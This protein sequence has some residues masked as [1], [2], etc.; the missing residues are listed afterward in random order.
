MSIR[1][2]IRGVVDD[3]VAAHQT[4]QVEGLAGGI[5]GDGAHFCILGDTLGGDVLITGQEDIR[6]DLVGNH[7]N[8]VLFV[9]LHGLLD[10]PFFPDPSR[11]VVGGAEDGGVDLVLAELGFHIGKVHSPHIIRIFYEPAVDNF[12]AVIFKGVGEADVGGAVDEH[13]VAPGAEGVQ[14]RDHAAQDAVFVADVLRLKPLNAV[15]GFVP[16]DDGVKIFRRGLEIAEGGVLGTLDHGLDNGGDN[17][18]IHVRHPHGDGLEAGQGR[19][20]A[21]AGLAHHVHGDGI[22]APA[23]HDGGKIVFHRVL[24]SG[25]FYS[26]Y[27]VCTA[28]STD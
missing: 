24:L 2:L 9:Q 16:A 4:R 23:I 19:I 22:L 6:P 1:S 8:I 5:E 15:S 13:L 3:V 7:K 28:R 20:G 21:E 17:G 14:R 26:A 25:L 11:G 10:L 18:E 27:R 12:V